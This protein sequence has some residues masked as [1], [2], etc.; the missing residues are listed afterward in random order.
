MIEPWKVLEGWESY[1]LI[2]LTTA[3]Q[4]TDGRVKFNSHSQ[5]EHRRCQE[6]SYQKTEVQQSADEKPH[7]SF[8]ALLPQQGQSNISALNEG[9]NLTGFVLF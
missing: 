8:Q 5:F 4:C 7:Y 9:L 6:Q 3:V 2:F 1:D